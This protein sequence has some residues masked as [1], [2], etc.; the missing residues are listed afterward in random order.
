MPDKGQ[1]S[2]LLNTLSS[3]WRLLSLPICKQNNLLKHSHFASIHDIQI[4]SHNTTSVFPESRT[5]LHKCLHSLINLESSLLHQLSQKMP[6][7]SLHC[8]FLILLTFCY[9]RFSRSQADDATGH[10]VQ[11]GLHIIWPVVKFLSISGVYQKIHPKKRKKRSINKPMPLCQS[12][13]EASIN[14]STRRDIRTPTNSSELRCCQNLDACSS[15]EKCLL[16]VRKEAYPPC[17][18]LAPVLWAALIC[19]GSTLLSM[20]TWLPAPNAV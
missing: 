7:H 5:S 9:A 6:T 13:P 20:S 4:S 3:C 19:C 1:P 15:A 2:Q 10:F 8:Q 17:H 11:T 18:A 14:R 12:I 16:H